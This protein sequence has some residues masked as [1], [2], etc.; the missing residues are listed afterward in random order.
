[1]QS[2]V[3]SKKKTSAGFLMRF[4][5]Y[6]LTNICTSVYNHRSTQVMYHS[7]TH[8]TQHALPHETFDYTAHESSASVFQSAMVCAGV[9]CTHPW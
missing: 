3:V 7:S 5:Q 4:A 9:T 2:L 6:K 1:M 8:V